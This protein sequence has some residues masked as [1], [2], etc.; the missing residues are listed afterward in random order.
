M[1]ESKITGND[2]SFLKRLGE[3]I[4]SQLEERPYCFVSEDHLNRCWP[5]NEML[6]PERNSEIRRFAKS[7]GWSATILERGFGT[8]AIFQRFEPGVVDYGGSKQ[9]H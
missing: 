6:Q 4:A 1:N 7:Q 5:G 8:R 2:S 3:H 9:C